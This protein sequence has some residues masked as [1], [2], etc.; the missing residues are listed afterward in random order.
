MKNEDTKKI[1]QTFALP[2]D[3]F[4]DL[5]IYV[6][7]SE[8]SR[9]VSNAI[10]KELELKKARKIRKAYLSVNKDLIQQETLEDWETTIYDGSNEW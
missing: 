6:K 2:A 9:F 1:N 10:R 3:I 8:I 7:K 4:Q 5:H